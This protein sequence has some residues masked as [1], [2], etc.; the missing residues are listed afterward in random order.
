M[1][2]GKKLLL[3]IYAVLALLAL[4]QAGTA[5]GIWAFRIILILAVAHVVEMLVYFK[6]CQQAGG[7]LARHLFNVFLFGV[8]H[9]KDIKAAQGNN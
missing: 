4:T 1:S 2:T 7:S 8:L 5:V 3:V 9:M 6:A